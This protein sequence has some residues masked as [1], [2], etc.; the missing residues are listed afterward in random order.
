MVRYLGLP[1]HLS[2]SLNRLILPRSQ[3][4][5]M[6]PKCP[7]FC[8]EQASFCSLYRFRLT[9]AKLATKF[10]SNQRKLPIRLQ[11]TTN[12]LGFHL[13]PRHCSHWWLVSF[14]LQIC[15]RPQNQATD[16]SCYWGLS[17]NFTTGSVD[18]Q[19]CLYCA[20]YWQA[21]SL[22]WHWEI[23]AEKR[24][25]SFKLCPFSFELKGLWVWFRSQPRLLEQNCGGKFT[26]TFR[27]P[28]PLYDSKDILGK[29]NFSKKAWKEVWGSRRSKSDHT[30]AFLRKARKVLGL[31]GN[32]RWINCRTNLLNLLP[33]SGCNI[34]VFVSKLQMRWL[35]VAHMR[36]RSNQR[37]RCCIPLYRLYI[38]AILSI[39][40]SKVVFYGDFHRLF[41]K[42]ETCFIYTN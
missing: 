35:T 24:L 17:G 3:I 36:F 32:K 5:L 20:D 9:P 19:T 16:C 34:G 21:R 30:V 31:G 4:H 27:H 11:H 41:Q 33:F 12:L 26:P 13:H 2:P 7:L 1:L 8:S 14:R 22:W 42:I 25:V 39:N 40:L 38:W 15:I 6:S 18:R 29:S 23:L 10:V 37:G 28:R